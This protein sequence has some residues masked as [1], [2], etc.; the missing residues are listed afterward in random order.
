MSQ[1]VGADS[2]GQMTIFC[3]CVLW[4]VAYFTGFE[5]RVFDQSNFFTGQSVACELSILEQVNFNPSLFS[6]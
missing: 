5:G 3:S 1:Y 6:F 4:P 2:N